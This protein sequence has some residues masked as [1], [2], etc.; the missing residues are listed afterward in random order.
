VRTPRLVDL[1]DELTAEGAAVTGITSVAEKS[2]DPVS[3]TGIPMQ[4]I[5]EIAASHHIPLYELAS[6]SGSLEDAYLALTSGEVE[7]KTEE[8]S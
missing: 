5:A 2:L 8:L 7:Y 6:A 4:R 1:A 3:V